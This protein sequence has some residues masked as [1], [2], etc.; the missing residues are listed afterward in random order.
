MIVV[1]VFAV[2]SAVLIPNFIRAREN[3]RQTA[4]QRAENAKPEPRPE[5]AEPLLESADVDL[6]LQVE[7]L[8]V[9]LDVAN[10]YVLEHQSRFLW[11][12]GDSKPGPLPDQR[13]ILFTLP[14]GVDQV[15][16]LL[17]EVGRDNSWSEPQE[18]TYGSDFIAWR[19]PASAFPL[20]TR[21]TY[22][23]HG[24]DRLVY[25]WPE[26]S[27]I[28]QLRASLTM[29]GQT[30]QALMPLGSLRPDEQSGSRYTWRLNNALAPAPIEVELSALDSPLGRA[31]RLFRLT[32]VA[33]LLFGAGFWYLAE[34]YK[35]GSL[36]DFRFGSFFLLAL[37][38]SSFFVSAAVLGVDGRW[39]APA[40]LSLSLAISLPLLIFHV[41]QLVDPRFAWTR[42]VPLALSTLGLVLLGVY[43]GE[44]RPLGF[45]ALALMAIGFLTATYRPFRR[46]QEYR[47]S[48]ADQALA[49]ALKDFEELRRQGR[50]VSGALISRLES[51]GKLGEL[52]TAE[53]KS[54]LKALQNSL[55]IA[56][57]T[58][59]EACEWNGSALA[60]ALERAREVCERLAGPTRSA[61]GRVE[62]R[63]LHC[64]Y[65]GCAGSGGPY[66]SQCGKRM[67]VAWDCPGCQAVVSIPISLLPMGQA[68]HCVDCGQRAPL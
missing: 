46:A 17:F 34:L 30:E 60:Q 6:A 37:T 50:E 40:Y 36:K 33:L 29:G 58:S 45:L 32:G 11:S 64:C 52:Y 51:D 65:C 9:G 66:C 54:H 55:D 31:G 49:R 2:I 68:F 8:R 48:L 38:Y 14:A 5:G 24:S 67:P 20:E 7:P 12:A 22:R 44:L 21:L 35:I 1:A 3:A 62:S 25:S 43:G 41:S 63:G 56:K 23:A 10:R 47:K 59:L 18:V 53:L 27:K 16:G 19:A 4:Q 13:L 26:A 42:A 28:R 57:P 39:S 61:D 15:E